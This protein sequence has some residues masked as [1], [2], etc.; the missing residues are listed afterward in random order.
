MSFSAQIAAGTR[1]T[2]SF[3]REPDLDH[4]VGINPDQR[5]IVWGAASL[6]VVGSA[7]SGGGGGLGS[8]SVSQRACD[9]YYWHL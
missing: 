5:I 4:C 3:G 1:K 2:G 8:P 9:I 7:D 6:A